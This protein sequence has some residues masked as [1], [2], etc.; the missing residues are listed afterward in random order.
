[1]GSHLSALLLRFVEV[2]LFLGHFHWQLDRFLTLAQFLQM[3][4]VTFSIITSV[5]GFNPQAFF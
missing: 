1:M 3:G 5:T 4:M 2:F